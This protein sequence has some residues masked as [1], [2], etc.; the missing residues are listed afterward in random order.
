M[1]EIEIPKSVVAFDEKTS[2]F[3]WSK[4]VTL[5]LE[6]SLVSVSKW[7]AKYHK[8]FLSREKKSAAEIVEYIKCMTI[9]QGVDDSV[10]NRLTQKNIEQVMNYIDDPMTATT[11]TRSPGEENRSNGTFTTNE[12]LYYAMFSYN[13]PKECEKW[14]LN[15]LITLIEVFNEKSK[16]QKKRSKR[17][18][19]LEQRALNE[20]RLAAWHTKG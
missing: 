7:E 1:L 12:T 18:A 19:I 14:H 5:R 10:Y 4:P 6:H 8:P 3:I 13:I 11:I 17:D 9:T 16:P 2:R 15:R 20:A